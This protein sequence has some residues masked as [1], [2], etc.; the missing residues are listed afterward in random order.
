MLILRVNHSSRNMISGRE[1]GLPP[2]FSILQLLFSLASRK[3][4]RGQAPFRACELARLELNLSNQL[5]QH[6]WLLLVQFS[7]RVQIIKI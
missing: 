1:G 2:L 5:S 6:T 4:R 3:I 7:A